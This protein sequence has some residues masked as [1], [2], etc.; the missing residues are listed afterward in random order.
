MGYEVVITWEWEDLQSLRPSWTEDKCVET[1][2]KISKTLKER[3]VEE[4]WDILRDLLSIVEAGTN[5]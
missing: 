4:G 1:L 2:I 3:S 5:A